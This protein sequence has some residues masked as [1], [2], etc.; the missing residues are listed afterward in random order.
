[1]IFGPSEHVHDSQTKLYTPKENFEP[2]CHSANQAD[3]PIGQSAQLANRLINPIS[4][5]AHASNQP[6]GQSAQPA[7]RLINPIS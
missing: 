2:I 3:Q 7:N 4:K 6:I 1:M 5:S